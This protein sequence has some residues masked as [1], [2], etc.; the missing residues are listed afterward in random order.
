MNTSI[1]SHIIPIIKEA[2]LSLKTTENVYLVT[3]KGLKVIKNT[4]NYPGRTGLPLE[5]LL[6]GYIL[7]IFWHIH[8]EIHKCIIYL[9]YKN[10]FRK[11]VNKLYKFQS[12]LVS[13]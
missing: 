7:S 11:G 1:Y 8:P 2:M 3:R 10:T 6:S 9:V 13:G 5:D 4:S 12:F